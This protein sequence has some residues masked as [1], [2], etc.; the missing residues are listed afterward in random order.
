M[1][2]VEADF[3]A[4]VCDQLKDLFVLS[5]PATGRGVIIVNDV[6]SHTTA[7]DSERAV[8]YPS[9]SRQHASGGD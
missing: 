7:T 5:L 9:G 3:F 2:N 6:G 8:G 4:L 1:A